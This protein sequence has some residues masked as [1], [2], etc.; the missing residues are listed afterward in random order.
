MHTLSGVRGSFILYPTINTIL[1][2]TIVV[3]NEIHQFCYINCKRNATVFELCI[4]NTIV[5]SSPKKDQEDVPLRTN[6]R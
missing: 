4:L 5:L 2:K 1:D 3:D 6:L